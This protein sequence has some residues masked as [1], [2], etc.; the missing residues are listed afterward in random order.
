MTRRRR[1]DLLTPPFRGHLHPLLAMARGLAG[2]HDV[3]IV[4]ARAGLGAIASLGLEGREVLAG[5]DAELRAIVD[6]PHA[7]GHHPLR[8]LRQF[9][10]AIGVLVRLRAEL[11]AL[12]SAAPP[13]LVIADF[14]LPVAGSVASELGM[15]WWTSLPSPCVLETRDGPPAYLGGW[16]PARSLPMRLVHA[17]GRGA[18]RTFKRAVFR[19]Q[20]RAIAA[21]GFTSLYRDDGSEQAYSPTRVLAVGMRELEFARTWPE[22]V[23]F[24]GPLLCTPP[25]AHEAPPFRPGRRHVLITLGTHLRWRKDAF[26]QEAQ[27]VAAALPD[28]D[29]HFSDGDP[30]GAR[31]SSHT[32]FTRVAYVDYERHLARY[33]LVVHHGGTGVLYACLAHGKPAVVCPF[34]YD[35]FDHAARLEVAGVALWCRRVRDLRALVQR[36]L[37]D[38]TLRARA[39]KFAPLVARYDGPALVAALV[40][41]HFG[42]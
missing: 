24:V 29:F 8:L 27:R 17:C 25:S 13:D 4:T 5:V 31:A 39:E 7:I 11:R 21:A 32:N 33:D 16:K 28:L 18:V 26:A 10:A 9:R 3:R 36:A 22:S 14:T 42:P 23:R 1:I 12:W 30:D 40:R 20:R 19:S 15:P 34:D 41:E 6:P 35:Q 37:G 38:R 2:E